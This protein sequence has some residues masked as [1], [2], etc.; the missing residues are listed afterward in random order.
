[1]NEKRRDQPCVQPAHDAEVH[2]TQLPLPAIDEVE[3]SLP[4]LIAAKSEMARSVS[5]L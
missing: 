4:L 2:P 1:M 3:P 5:S